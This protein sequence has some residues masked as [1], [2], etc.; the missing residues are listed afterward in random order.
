MPDKMINVLSFNTTQMETENI[1]FP[2]Q[3]KNELLERKIIKKLIELHKVQKL[4]WWYLA[5]YILK[6][7]S[8]L[9]IF[10]KSESKAKCVTI[11][12]CRACYNFKQWKFVNI[13]LG[14][15]LSLRTRRRDKIS[16]TIFSSLTS[17]MISVTIPL[18]LGGQIRVFRKSFKKY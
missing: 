7:I 9:K 10:R 16:R 4:K 12:V 11:F 3:D 18:F 6:A 13:L 2:L 14:K 5:L 15:I 1:T 17:E 8:L